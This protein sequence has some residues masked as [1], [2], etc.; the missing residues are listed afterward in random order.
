MKK[1]EEKHIVACYGTL[2]SGFGNH[3]CFGNSKMIAKGETVEKMKM[4]AS[5]IPFVT[6]KEKISPIKVE[7]Y[8]VN[9]E[10]L[11]RLDCLEGHPSFYKREV[12]DIKLEDGNEA[13]AWMYFCDRNAAE[14]VPT[15]DYRDYRKN[16]W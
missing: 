5:G 16:S 15:G 4:T 9:D 3:R 10:I 14:V 6:K 7:V 1:K 8:E 11:Y 13:K 12:T 2:M